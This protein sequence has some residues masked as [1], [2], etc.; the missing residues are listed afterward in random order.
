[1]TWEIKSPQGLAGY[2]YRGH[3]GYQMCFFHPSCAQAWIE[4]CHILDQWSGLLKLSTRP[5]VVSDFAFVAGQ[6]ELNSSKV[7][8][9]TNLDMILL[10]LWQK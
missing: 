10:L 8:D 4:S 7:Q 5:R 3:Y 9:I 1:M 2:H 6:A